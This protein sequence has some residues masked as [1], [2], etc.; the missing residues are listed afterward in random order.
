M[1]LPTSGALSFSAIQTE[2]GGTNPITMSEYYGRTANIA[3][4]GTIKTSM[5]YGQSA[6]SARMDSVFAYDMALMPGTALAGIKVDSDGFVYK[7]EGNGSS[8]VSQFQWKTGPNAASSYEVMFTKA[9]GT[10]PGTVNTWI[11]CSTD[12]IWE[13]SRSALGS[14]LCSGTIT[15]R[16]A[17]GANLASNTVTI[18]ADGEI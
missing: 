13:L 4:S 9:S 10:D 14:T 8:W 15:I 17:G 2:F 11:S 1:T 3:A 16:A 7:R 18:R 5:F 12:Q 6:D